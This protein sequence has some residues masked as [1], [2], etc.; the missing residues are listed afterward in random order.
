MNHTTVVNP[1]KTLN[2]LFDIYDEKNRQ[3]GV[4]IKTYT[5]QKIV[6]DFTIEPQKIDTTI[7][8]VASIHQT[9]NNQTFG[10]SY[11]R[12]YYKTQAEM[13]QW[14]DAKVP[15]LQNTYAKKFAEM[16]VA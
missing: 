5:H 10:G 12:G 8:F 13:Q 11:A 1:L 14:I 3:L 7:Y 15:S 4:E 2:I 9:R 16:A 6:N